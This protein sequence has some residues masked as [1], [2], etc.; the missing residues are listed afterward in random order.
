MLILFSLLFL[1]NTS[2]NLPQHIYI[3]DIVDMPVVALGTKQLPDGNN[4]ILVDD[5]YPT[6]FVGSARL[7]EGNT[8]IGGH[9]YSAFKLLHRVQL[10]DEIL[11]NDYK[12]TIKEIV[13]VNE[14]TYEDRVNNSR[15]ATQMGDVRLTLITCLDGKSKRIIVVGELK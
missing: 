1:L 9:D 2:N 15:Y 6:W 11:V 13:V 8:V 12:F 3:K 5:Y 10:D 7:G 4:I 14:V